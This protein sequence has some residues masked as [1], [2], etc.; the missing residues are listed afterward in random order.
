ML[1]HKTLERVLLLEWGWEACKVTQRQVRLGVCMRW[2]E[3]AW[4]CVRVSDVCVC[5]GESV[6]CVYVWESECL[7][8]HIA[9]SEGGPGCGW[10]RRGGNKREG[11]GCV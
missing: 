1:S 6:R 5:M 3:V 2:G 10:A 7:L 9:A 4:S 8:H 11:R